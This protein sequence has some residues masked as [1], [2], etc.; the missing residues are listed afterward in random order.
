VWSETFLRVVRARDRYQGDGRFRP[1]LLTIARRCAMD[2]QRT[3]RRVFRLAIKVFE[4]TPADEGIVAGPDVR[5]AR[6]QRQQT[7]DA[8]LGRLKPT[9]RAIVDLTYREDLDSTEIGEILG[10]S[11]QE[12]RSRL[13]YARRLLRAEL[14]GAIDD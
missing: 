8:A 5:I 14:E 12:V 1:W 13:T 9:H 3:G 6:T 11:A 4:R 7:V 10:L 2:E